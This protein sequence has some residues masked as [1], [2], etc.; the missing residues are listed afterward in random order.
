MYRI[1]MILFCIAMCSC[2]R[3]YLSSIEI[4]LEHEKYSKAEGNWIYLYTIDGNEY[5]IADSCI[6]KNLRCKLKSDFPYE[7][8]YQLL[9][10]ATQHQYEFWMKP[11]DHLSV[12]LTSKTTRRQLSIPESFTNIASCRLEDA[13]GEQTKM[14]LLLKDSLAFMDIQNPAYKRLEDSMRRIDTYRR[15][16]LLIELLDDEYIRQSPRISDLIVLFLDANNYEK[17]LDSLRKAL[18]ERFPNDHHWMHNCTGEGAPPASDK[19]IV[20]VNRIRHL[21]GHPPV[22]KRRE[23][24]VAHIPDNY[25]K[26][27]AYQEGD[28]IDTHLFEAL[29]AK[30]EN[31]SAVDSPYILLDFWASWCGPCCE[32]IPN[33]LK[34]RESY[35]DLL[36]VYAVSLDH[37]TDSWQ[38]ALDKYGIRTSFLHVMLPKSHEQYQYIMDKFAIKAIPANFLLDKDRRII[39]INLRGD[40]LSKKMNELTAK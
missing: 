22:E 8:N 25:I 15:Q 9:I 39:S 24:P 1:V 5:Y 34:V 30:P 31:L 32:E 20:A 23:E 3:D 27:E 2:K 10:P 11:G 29:E 13:L 19:S 26:P 14:W 12:N 37:W 4:T 38:E 21:M 17:Q 40:A 28:I 33:I 6:V 7:L 16:G 36:S 35:S 18:L